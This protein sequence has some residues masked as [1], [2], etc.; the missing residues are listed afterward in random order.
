MTF[1]RTFIGQHLI[2]H[3]ILASW[4]LADQG[5]AP[6]LH[7]ISIECGAEISSR[8]SWVQ[9]KY[10]TFLGG[11]YTVPNGSNHSHSWYCLSS[12]LLDFLFAENSPPKRK[13]PHNICPRSW[14]FCSVLTRAVTFR[15]LL[16]DMMNMNIQRSRTSNCHPP[17]ENG[18]QFKDFQ[19]MQSDATCKHL[20]CIL[21]N[22]HILAEKPP[23]TWW[24]PTYWWGEW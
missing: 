12:F 5:G 15:R 10:L 22:L 6:L 8:P 20:H 21:F 19:S 13:H 3:I 24:K 9:R 14:T 11:F 1:H 16:N 7:R 17:R 4:W 2:Q 18:E 23:L